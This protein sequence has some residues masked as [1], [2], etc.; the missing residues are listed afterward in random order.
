VGCSGVFTIVN[1]DAAI[2]SHFS[3]LIENIDDGERVFSLM[4]FSLGQDDSVSIEPP[5]NGSLKFV[6]HGPYKSYTLGLRIV[7]GS[8]NGIFEHAGL[9]LPEGSSHTIVPAWNNLES[10]PVKILIDSG[11]DGSIDDSIFV[12]NQ[13]VAT[14][15]QFFDVGHRGE[16]IEIEWRLSQ[17]D[18]DVEFFV[19]RAQDGED[20]F[21]PMP[22]LEIQARGMH[23]RVIDAGIEPDRDYRYQIWYEIEG[24]RS[25]LFETD[26]IR[27]PVL[28]LTLFQNYPNPFNPA[29]TIKYFLPG[30]SAVRIDIFD[31]SGRRVTRLV[32]GIQGRGYHVAVWNG[33]N[34]NGQEVG[35]GVYFYR[36]K[37]G[38]QVLTRK[39]VI[40]R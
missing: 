25:I 23:F 5:A 37:S 40:L 1:P 32:N 11:N 3:K 35:S 29:T 18:D 8:E 6:N 16:F 13:Y 14:L 4:Q 2:K 27:T 19:S 21:T 15:L 7:T 9:V 33:R 26:A 36:L 38:K 17:L 12:D 30:K 34:H 28:A 22:D 24:Q 20:G 39:M 31:V 10:I